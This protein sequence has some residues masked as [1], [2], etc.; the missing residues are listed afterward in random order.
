MKKREV[1][2]ENKKRVYWLVKLV[3]EI[4]EGQFIK[5]HSRG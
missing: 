5:L 1:I 3:K 4:R 2:N